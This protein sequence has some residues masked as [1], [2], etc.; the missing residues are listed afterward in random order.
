MEPVHRTKITD[1]SWGTIEVKMG[2][3]TLHFRD[4]K[5]WPGGARE[6]D[7]NE[8]GTG[9]SPGVQIADV[10]ELFDHDPEVIILSKGQNRRLQV[11]QET[12]LFLEKQGI[13]YYLEETNQAVKHFN[14][15]SQEGKQVAGLF[16]T[17]C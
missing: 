2:D 12:R 15:L 1:L 10:E 8:T 7:W 11:K 13:S 14:E 17:T 3:K 9:H 6:W 5:I 16:H 4:A